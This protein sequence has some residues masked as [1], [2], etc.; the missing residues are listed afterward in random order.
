MPYLFSDRIRLRAA[1]KE[2]I[3]GFL[4]WVNDE[5]VTENLFL[6]DPM[7]RFE[8]ENW[9]ESMMKRPSSEHALVI[10]A[11]DQSPTRDYR[12]IGTCQFHNLD[13]RNRCAEIGIMIGEKIF[14][15]QGYGTETMRLLLRHGFDT[16]NL[17]R[18]WLQVYAKNKRGIRA[19]EKA[20]FVH[21]G[22]YRQAHYQ[23]GQYHD[24]HLMSV[25]KEEW[26]VQNQTQKVISKD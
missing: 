5:D 7:S 14:W 9:Y 16:L 25:L 21:E 17:H 13:W 1:E 6:I 11:I 8:E 18:I 24:V 3:T 4:R 23:H 26:Q 22:K 19:Y 2:D 12:P 10:E 15:D 20:G